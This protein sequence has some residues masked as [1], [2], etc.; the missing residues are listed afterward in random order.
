MLS[1]TEL[2]FPKSFSSDIK[3][4]LRNCNPKDVYCFP[5]A[6]ASG[7]NSK[8]PTP[9]D[10]IETGRKKKKSVGWFSKKKL[11]VR[12][13]KQSDALEVYPGDSWECIYRWTCTAAA[14]TFGPGG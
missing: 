9:R 4:Y 2:A 10:R 7:K 14:L 12:V 6:R 5:F 11:G 13:E 3:V 8:F 1:S